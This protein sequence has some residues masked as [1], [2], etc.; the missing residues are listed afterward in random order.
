MRHFTL[1]CLYAQRGSRPDLVVAAATEAWNISRLLVEVDVKSVRRSLFSLQR[2]VID[3]I[4]QS[5]ISEPQTPTILQQ[6][7]LA[8]TS[9][10]CSDLDWNNAL[11]VVMEAFEYVPNE[12]QKPLWRWRVIIMSKL[13]KN[14]LDGIQKLKEDDPSLQARVYSIL[15]RAS[16][17]P[18]LQLGGYSKSVEALA[19]QLPTNPEKIEYL[20]ETGFLS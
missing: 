16:P 20:L 3:I 4:L 2:Q 10:H 18:A 13:G 5:A 7:Y 14:V 8:V 17:S 11:K 1:A 9:Q 12:L 19:S 6:F 15:A